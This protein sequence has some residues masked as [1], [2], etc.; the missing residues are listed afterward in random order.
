MALNTHALRFVANRK[1]RVSLGSKA[2]ETCSIRGIDQFTFDAHIKVGAGATSLSQKAYMET[3]GTRANLRFA[4]TPTRDNG[5]SVLVFEFSRASN[6]SPTSYRYEL[7]N[8]WDD[9]WHHVAFSVSTGD[10]KY[11]IF[12]DDLKVKE[13]RLVGGG[14][15]QYNRALLIDDAIPK[16]ISIGAAPTGSSSNYVYWDGKIDN[17][18]LFRKF[19]NGNT[20]SS[21]DSP[22]DDHSNKVGS[23]AVDINLIEEWRFNEGPLGSAMGMTFGVVDHQYDPELKSVE[24]ANADNPNNNQEE[25]EDFDP[26]PPDIAD[27]TLYEDTSKSSNLWTGV[28]VAD[29]IVNASGVVLLSRDSDRPFIGEG[30][31]DTQP[32]PFPRT[33]LLTG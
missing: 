13:G 22:I 31:L 3:H 18:R 4:C 1:M 14:F 5:R 21:A 17:V 6:S 30:L 19:V 2:R 15:D 9:R 28:D 16:E 32:P 24:Y 25:E 27:A 7:P 11:A 29:D 8:G 20:Y 12:F 23:F 10:G 33:L 26:G